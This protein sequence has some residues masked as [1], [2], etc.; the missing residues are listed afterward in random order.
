MPGVLAGRM[1]PRMI[2]DPITRLNT[3]LEGRYRIES[4]LGKGGMATVYLADDIKHERKVAL[5]VLKPE[6]A[7][8]VGAERFLAEIK[9]TANLTHPHILPLFD[10]GEA[11][12][13]LFYV[14]PHVEGES[15]RQRLDREHQL[16]VDDA[17]QIA[18]DVAEALE[19]AH[20]HGVIHRDIKPANIL[21]QAGKPVIADFGIALAVSAGGGHRLTETGLSLGTPHYMS[22]EQATGDQHVGPATDIYALGCV[23]YE[24]LVGEPPYTGS[25]AQAILG[26]IIAG[27]LATA[28]KQRASVPANVDAAIAKA[29]E[30][31]PADRF[32]GAQDFAN[33][34]ADPAFRH[35]D[36]PAGMAAV[37]A[38][39]WNRVTTA[40][41]AS[42]ALLLGVMGWSLTRAP[43]LAPTLR[44][45]LAPMWGEMERPIG[46]Y[47]ALA[48]DGS[49]IV[50]A[51]T[52][53]IAAGWQLWYKSKGSVEAVALGGTEGAR[54]VIYAPDSE[55]IAFVSGTDL[56]S[57]PIGDGSTV[58]VAEGIEGNMIGVAWMD[59]ATILFEGAGS[60]V[61]RIPEGGGVADTVLTV[62][63]YQE[64]THL[65]P[66]PGSSGAL[67]SLCVT[68]CLNGSELHVIDLDQGTH[69]LLL[70]DVI[71][72]WYVPTGHLVYVRA[73]G[74]VFAAPFDLETLSLT[75]T[76]IPLFD[77]VQ[78]FVSSPELAVADDGTVLYQRGRAR[79]SDRVVVWVDR[80]GTVTRVDPDNLGPDSYYHVALSPS[81]DRVALSVANAQGS[82]GLW[83]KQLPAGPMTPLTT[84]DELGARPDWS[85]DGRSVAYVFGSSE[86]WVTRS[87]GSAPRETLLISATSVQELQ[88]LPDGSGFLTRLGAR[89]TSDIGVY[90]PASDSVTMLL[91]SEFA[92][93]SGRVSPDGAWI[94]YVSDQSGTSQVYV[95]PFPEMDALTQVSRI[96]SNTP[97]W[98]HNGRELFYATSDGVLTVATY[99]T[100]SGFVVTGRTEIIDF[101][102]EN[103]YMPVVNW[104]AFDVSADD[105]RI[106]TLQ[107]ATG[108]G[109]EDGGNEVVYIQNFFTELMARF[110]N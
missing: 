7:A 69:V 95:R 41:A 72:A 26:K 66:L 24:M 58:T 1:L 42:T 52:D 13:F 99:E 76:G 43:E 23:L 71:R 91:S 87:D 103:F 34:L 18:S 15:L 100:E 60:S 68:G 35:G 33:A 57:R 22:P 67:M 47:S 56:K 97:V 53:D 83:V 17:V 61:V 79:T 20:G 80:S 93:F 88:H 106:I 40:L 78:I 94:A 9:T 90:D 85:L 10:S 73:D 54:N 105:Q 16:P 74:A 48:P 82:I 51:R 36:L 110:G 55:R 75:G 29:L 3:A 92:E 59:D 63:G 12:S 64:L 81:N 32:T 30:K 19:Y 25:T 6:L 44:Q 21:L 102:A 104:K 37:S 108:S 46:K 86:S 4:E 2:D 84:G 8:V 45:E 11:D 98:A 28:T 39:P 5:K 14:M 65:A 38:G 31:L 89:Q 62:E 70:E 27:D 107:N 109:D 77:G 101:G 96:A 49:G 50:F